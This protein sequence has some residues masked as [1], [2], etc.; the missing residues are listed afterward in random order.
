MSLAGASKSIV[1]TA[2][3]PFVCLDLRDSEISSGSKVNSDV[4]EDGS[5]NGIAGTA[6]STPPSSLKSFTNE[7]ENMTPA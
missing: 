4:G 7:E 1:Q 3:P 5:T 6:G 2:K